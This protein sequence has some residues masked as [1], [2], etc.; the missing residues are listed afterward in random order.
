[1]AD[2]PGPAEVKLLLA[3]CGLSQTDAA[4]YLDREAR[5]VRRWL[6]GSYPVPTEHWA[7][8]LDLCAR[9]DRAAEETLAL[10]REQAK[11]HGAPREVTIRLSRSQDGAAELGWPCIGAHLA[12]IR[13]VAEW[14]PKAITVRAV[15]PGESEAADVAAARRTA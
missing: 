10:V 15:Y 6:D 3:R 5:L 1:M 2:A 13:R 14:A 11:Q 8:L 7:R 12:V 4:A 9:Q